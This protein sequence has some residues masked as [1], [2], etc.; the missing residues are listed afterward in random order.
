MIVFPEVERNMLEGK[1]NLKAA[2]IEYRKNNPNG[3]RLSQFALHFRLWRQNMGS[4]QIYLKTFSVPF[5]SER[6]INILKLWRRSNNR[7]LWAKAV[8]ILDRHNG[9]P[10]T[11]LCMKLEKSHRI[12][13]R[14]IN[15]YLEKGIDGLYSPE[16]RSMNPEKL[17]EM[18]KKRDRIV[19]ILHES[20]QLH[21]I[22]RAS[23]S[24]DT[25]SC[26]YEAQFGEPIGRSTV[27]EYIR[28]EG[29]TF[30][31]A[32]RVL[33]SPDPEYRIKMKE[34]NDILSNLKNDE[35]FFSIDEFGPF[36]VKL[37]GGRSFT[38]P[39]TVRVIP[40]WQHGRGHLILTGA[41][42]L[43]SNQMTHFYSDK[44][45]TNEMI[46]LLDVLLEQYADQHCVYLSWDAASWHISS[47]LAK[48][49]I[50]LNSESENA[51]QRP[52]VKL[53]TLPSSAQFLNVIESVFS[54]MAKAVLHNS[55][56]PTVDH[57]KTA[58]DTYIADRNKHY[59]QYPQ[60]AGNKIWGK[61][62]VEPDFKP[63]NNCKNRRWR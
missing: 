48:Y 4:G 6:D 56:Y 1:T 26:A 5:I 44:K 52:I 61:E 39:G 20:P 30:R 34:I 13:E 41:L 33:T 14:W 8:T 15:T 35:K 62:E 49:V 31:K 55:N 51:Q 9:E 21:N 27:S 53:A 25:I 59:R 57:C 24:L 46:R 10:I 28:A 17:K 43:S 22:N 42:E 54:G 23:W 18:Q 58:I 11:S 3:Y 36:T 63:S 16:S 12:I 29:Y 7:Q 40:Q 50:Q 38:P 19:E 2:W 32:R 45:N 47:K 60:R 37:Q